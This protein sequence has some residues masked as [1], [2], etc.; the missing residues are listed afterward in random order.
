MPTTVFYARQ[1]FGL[2]ALRYGSSH[3]TLPFAWG[4]LSAG[5]STFGFGEYREVHLSAGVARSFQFGTSREVHF[6]MTARYYNTSISSY[7]SAGAL[8]VNGGFIVRLLRSLR[9]GAH[10]TNLTGRALVEGEP[11]PQTLA[12][13]L[14]YRPVDRMRVLVDLFKDVQF[15]FSVRGGLEIRP[16]GLLALRAGVTTAPVRFSGGAGVRLDPVRADIAVE[17]HQELGW[18]PSASL[19]I[20][21]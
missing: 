6:G 21:W 9:L 13:G 15:P 19:R 12:V 3:V 2:S 7:G 17:Q 11:L 5:A 4:A 20:H 8:A 1:S 16:V 10:A 18:S 14:E